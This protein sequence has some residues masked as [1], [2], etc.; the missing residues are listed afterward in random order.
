MVGS[1]LPLTGGT[2]NGNLTV[3]AKATGT[4]YGPTMIID[5][6]SIRSLG[7]VSLN[8]TVVSAMLS[9]PDM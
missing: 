3:S 4:N 5:G 9:E 2:I 1:Y 7:K 8:G 6:S